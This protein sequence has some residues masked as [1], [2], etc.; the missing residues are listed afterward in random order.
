MS[1]LAR[2]EARDRDAERADHRILAARLFDT[3]GVTKGATAIPIGDAAGMIAEAVTAGRALE[4]ALQT[5]AHCCRVCGCTE[6]RACEGGCWWVEP[7][8]CS[9]CEFEAFAS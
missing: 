4:L 9:A 7:D 1:G 6:T 2:I 3:F 5:G 8:L